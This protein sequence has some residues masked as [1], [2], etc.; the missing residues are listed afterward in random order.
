MSQIVQI[1]RLELPYLIS[2]LDNP[3]IQRQARLVHL[4]VSILVCIFI[5]N[6]QLNSFLWHILLSPILALH[7]HIQWPG[8]TAALSVLILSE[9]YY[10]PRTPTITLL[11]P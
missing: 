5:A 9:L 8:L 4:C 3:S 7:I 10:L 6:M 1:K 11:A 2:T